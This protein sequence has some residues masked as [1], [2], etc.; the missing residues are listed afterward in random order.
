MDIVRKL[1]DELIRK[2]GFLICSP[3][4][5]EL[6]EDIRHFKES[7]DKTLNM[8][9]EVD[10]GFSIIRR[11]RHF[12]FLMDLWKYTRILNTYQIWLRCFQINKNSNFSVWKSIHW[13]TKS[14]SRV[15]WGLLNI[16]E[17]NKFMRIKNVSNL[18]SNNFPSNMGRHYSGFS[19][20]KTLNA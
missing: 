16:A 12:S 14:K 17:R 6:C 3:Q 20:G 9:G 4:P 2:I 8:Y 1:P 13:G 10:S 11:P 7:Y 19:I 15:L 5:K 18:C